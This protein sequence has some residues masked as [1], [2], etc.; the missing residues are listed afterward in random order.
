MIDLYLLENPEDWTQEL[1]DE[2]QELSEG[3]EPLEDADNMF[4]VSSSSKDEPHKVMLKARKKDKV[5]LPTKQKCKH[6]LALEFA[7]DPEWATNSIYHKDPT[8]PDKVLIG[9]C[10]CKAFKYTMSNGGGKKPQKSTKEPNAVP[11]EKIQDT[12]PV[13][14]DLPEFGIMI[15][16]G[17]KYI[18][19]EGLLWGLHQEFP[20]VIIETEALVLEPKRAVV[21]CTLR[22]GEGIMTTGHGSAVPSPVVKKQVTEMAE[23]RAI[24]RAIR[25]LFDLPLTGE[26]VV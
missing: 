23:T 13:F 11:L 18:K 25:H 24:N 9:A 8:K 14:Q 2:A 5:N 7:Y 4:W 26:E 21:R 6:I 22:N 16:H 19:K 17:K 20:D 15:L 12:A 10:D 1:K 3:I